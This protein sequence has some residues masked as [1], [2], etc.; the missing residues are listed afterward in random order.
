MNLLFQLFK[1]I[2]YYTIEPFKIYYTF[3]KIHACK[4]TFFVRN[5]CLLPV[6]VRP[7]SIVGVI[8]HLQVLNYGMLSQLRREDFRILAYSKHI[9][10]SFIFT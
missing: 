4:Q 10:T 7:S 8:D 9:K 6:V 2:V 1:T 5:A 3:Y